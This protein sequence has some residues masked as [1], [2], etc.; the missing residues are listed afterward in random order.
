MTQ[1]WWKLSSK[2]R[3]RHW[4][5]AFVLRTSVHLLQ[6]CK[7]RNMCKMTKESQYFGAID[8]ITI[9]SAHSHR[10]DV[11]GHLLRSG[12]YNIGGGGVD[13]RILAVL[14]ASCLRRGQH[15]NQA[16][17]T[18]DRLYT[19]KDDKLQEIIHLISHS[20][21]RIQVHP[22][23]SL[24]SKKLISGVMQ[25]LQANWHITEQHWMQWWHLIWLVIFLFLKIWNE[26]YRYQSG[27]ILMYCR[28]PKWGYWNSVCFVVDDIRQPQDRFLVLKCKC[29]CSEL[30]K[31]HR[32]QVC[33]F[34]IIIHWTSY[35]KH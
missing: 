4:Y 14:E 2:H 28:N 30:D 35:P 32:M 27:E 3:M 16:F 22:E 12:P 15:S 24:D 18:L 25:Q 5:P 11:H 34:D 7:I 26:C 9:T 10:G 21:S 17:Y 8:G 1:I 29:G 6:Y 23:S 33:I 19:V 13:T 31:D 20:T